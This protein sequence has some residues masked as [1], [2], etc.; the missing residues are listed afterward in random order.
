MNIPGMSFLDPTIS[1]KN[2]EIATFDDKI[3]DC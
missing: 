2:E 1:D 3:G